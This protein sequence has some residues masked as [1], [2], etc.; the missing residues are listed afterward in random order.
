LYILA[1][2]AGCGILQIQPHVPLAL[3][4]RILKLPEQHQFPCITRRLLEKQQ[5]EKQEGIILYLRFRSR[6]KPGIPAL[7][8]REGVYKWSTILRLQAQLAY[9]CPGRYLSTFGVAPKLKGTK[10]K[11][12]ERKL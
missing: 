5:P 11:A 7:A 1:P 6:G 10:T 9:L 8:R 12:R 3:V 2:V 4:L